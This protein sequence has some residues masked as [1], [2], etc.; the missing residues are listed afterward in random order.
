MKDQSFGYRGN[1]QTTHC[2]LAATEQV[3]Q[4]VPTSA[5][6]DRPLGEAEGRLGEKEGLALSL[7]AEGGEQRTVE[8]STAVD[9]SRCY[10]S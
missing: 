3:E 8:T 4:P 2:S 6:Q 10:E 1:C 9:C 7:Q 5:L